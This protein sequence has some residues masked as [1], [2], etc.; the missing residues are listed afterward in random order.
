MMKQKTPFVGQQTLAYHPS[1]STYRERAAKHEKDSANTNIFNGRNISDNRPASYFYQCKAEPALATAELRLA[2]QPQRLREQTLYQGNGEARFTQHM[3][4]QAYDDNATIRA[5]KLPSALV[6]VPRINERYETQSY[7][8]A[9]GRDLQSLRIA[10][11]SRKDPVLNINAAFF[12]HTQSQPAPS[13]PY[14]EIF[15]RQREL[16]KQKEGTQ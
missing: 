4:A 14:E 1:N 3:L 15:Q 9:A 2:Q 8:Q 13:D 5:S 11:N 16:Q 7:E 6:E 12:T 10:Q